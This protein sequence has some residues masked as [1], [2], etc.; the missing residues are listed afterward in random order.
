MINLLNQSN[1][2]VD[3]MGMYLQRTTTLPRFDGDNL[4]MAVL[5]STFEEENTLRS[6]YQSLAL[7]FQND[8][9]VMVG[10]RLNYNSSKI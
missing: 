3:E 5:R 8:T 1:P 10:Q 7:A 4:P 2:Y 6:R 9:P